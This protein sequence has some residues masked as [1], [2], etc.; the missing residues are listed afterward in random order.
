[1]KALTGREP[2]I[3]RKSEGAIELVCGRGHL[4]GFKRFAE[5]ADVIAR[6]LE[7]TSRRARA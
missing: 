7:E 6:W 3:R 4:D 5:L 1:V 2:R